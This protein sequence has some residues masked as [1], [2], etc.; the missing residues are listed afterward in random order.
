MN[1]LAKNTQNDEDPNHDIIT[2]IR[3]KGVLTNV[4][5]EANDAE[6]LNY[7]LS[8][9]GFMKQDTTEYVEV[10]HI[11]MKGTLRK[12]VCAY[13][14]GDREILRMLSVCTANKKDVKCHSISITPNQRWNAET[15]RWEIVP[16][17]QQ[18]LKNKITS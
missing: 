17:P 1:L 7:Y 4:I 2:C 14:E 15:E 8:L 3:V 6:R 10:K 16:I 9:V 5:I 11:W 18:M 12:K 13:I